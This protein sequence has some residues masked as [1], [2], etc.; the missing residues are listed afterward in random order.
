MVSAVEYTAGVKAGQYVKYGNFA[1]IPEIEIPTDY[2]MTEVIEVS[3][4]MVKLRATGQFKNGTPTPNNG[5]EASYNVQTG[6]IEDNDYDY[7][8]GPIIAGNLNEGDPVPPLSY[9]FIINK[10]E[11]RTYLG[12]SRAVNII[13]TTS[14][15][16]NY[17][18][19]WILVYDKASGLLM[20]QSFE[21]TTKTPTLETI[22]Q[23]Y[24]VI[25]TNIFSDS[26]DDGAATLP[27]D[28]IL[29]VALVA[30]VIIVVAAFVV[31]R[32]RSKTE[33]Q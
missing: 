8:Y 25:E 26:S 6:K 14:S 9:N 19:H 33:P 32:K 31:M 22:S 5:R 12:Y 24:S 2:L 1:T 18:N 13:E 30:M 17:A 16:E 10:T 23:S 3:G 4:S 27:V 20:E 21:L 15:D 7:T 28:V 11:T 29:I